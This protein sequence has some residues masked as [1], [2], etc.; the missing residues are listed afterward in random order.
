MVCV[1]NFRRFPPAAIDLPSSIANSVG[2]IFALCLYDV[3]RNRVVAASS[4]RAM[5]QSSDR[6]YSAISTQLSVRHSCVKVSTS[7]QHVGFHVH[8]HFARS[9]AI[10]AD[11]Y[12]TS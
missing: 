6:P 10:E 7:D 11:T 5:H 3:R 1:T 9:T 4:G 2:P 12:W 8:I